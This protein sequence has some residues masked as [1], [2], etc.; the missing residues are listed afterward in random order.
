MDLKNQLAFSKWAGV[1]ANAINKALKP[2]DG[3]LE[4]FPGTKK[5]DCDSV[6]S[7]A[8]KAATN[9]QRLIK[10]LNGITEPTPNTIPAGE[11]EDLEETTAE[12]SNDIQK[13]AKYRA[14]TEKQKEQNLKLKNKNLEGILVEKQVILTGALM[15][16]D[17]IH[18][19]LDR[20]FGTVMDDL[21]PRILAA[22]DCT[23]EIV[24]GSIDEGKRIVHE[25]K[26]E[27]LKRVANIIED[28]KLKIKN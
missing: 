7:Q 17:Q 28:N 21:A 23:P 12:M 9:P 26:E 27:F 3:R 18:Q 11:P 15:Y 20:F 25:G 24:Q 13:Y 5:I 2:E 10:V 19:D 14:G 1:S 16:F 8:F 6:K 22:G 4:F